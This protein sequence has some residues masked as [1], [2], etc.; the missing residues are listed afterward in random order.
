M[1]S[2]EA[3]IIVLGLIGAVFFFGTGRTISGLVFPQPTEQE[4]FI[5][6]QVQQAKLISET[7]G[8]GLIVTTTGEIIPTAKPTQIAGGDITQ[9][10]QIIDPSVT[11]AEEKRI[12]DI[13]I[14]AER[15]RQAELAEAIRTGI[16]LR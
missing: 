15:K 6:A 3:L 2:S 16:P 8:T 9:P 7:T 5:Q 4:I 10:T 1:V 14:D 12:F 11:T 13:I